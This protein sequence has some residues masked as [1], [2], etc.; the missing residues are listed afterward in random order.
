MVTT[1]SDKLVVAAPSSGEVRLLTSFIAPPIQSSKR[2]DVDIVLV[3]DKSGSMNGEKIRLLKETV[4]FITDQLSENDRLGIVSYSDIAWLELPLFRLGSA[5]NRAKVHGIVDAIQEG[6]ST[7]L[8]A[9]LLEGVKMLRERTGSDVAD[10][11]A[12]VLLLTDGHA[13][14][15]FVSATDINR[16]IVDPNFASSQPTGMG[17]PN[18]FLPCVM[19]LPVQMMAQQQHLQSPP[20]QCKEHKATAAPMDLTAAAFT[21]A[22]PPLTASK[23]VVQRQRVPCSIY[24]FGFGTHHDEGLLQKLTTNGGL[25]Y[26]IRDTDSIGEHFANCLGGLTSVAAQSVV[27]T[28]KPLRPNVHISCLMNRLEHHIDNGELTVELGDIQSSETKDVVIS[29][30]VDPDEEAEMSL[31]H[32]LVELPQVL[33]EVSFKNMLTGNTGDVVS[34]CSSLYRCSGENAKAVADAVGDVPNLALDV[35]INRLSAAA[36]ME[37]A[38]DLG[39]HSLDQGRAVL[40]SAI[41]SIRESPS[42]AD[43]FCIALVRDLQ[44]MMDGMH[45]VRT[46]SNDTSKR[47]KSCAAAQQMQRCSDMT[48]EC[49]Q[50]FVTPT[51][52]ALISAEKAYKS[53]SRK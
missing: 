12:S 10:R 20:K 42:A 32:V 5:A 51:R 1:Q 47:M 15:G 8:C 3:L 23:A 28:A 30:N 7:A 31:P 46:F 33:V 36:A 52:E 16:A 45:D 49:Q 38:S 24:T 6:G 19:Q 29:Y 27:L 48:M 26:F 39:A 40:H 44:A 11:V 9:G 43:P 35:Q 18:A 4:H 13:N 41:Q 21:T 14:K 37:D 17:H 34:A 53:A 25:Y 2:P 50:T 22:S